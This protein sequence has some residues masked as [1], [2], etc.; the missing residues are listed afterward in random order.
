MAL[1]PTTEITASEWLDVRDTV[2]GIVKTAARNVQQQTA[3]GVAEALLRRGY[4]DVAQVR[5]ALQNERHVLT[6]PALVDD[7]S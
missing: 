1:T 3:V 4:V 2:A 6:D 5:T 7:P